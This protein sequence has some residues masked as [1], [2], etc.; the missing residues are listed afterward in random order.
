MPKLLTYIPCEKVVIDS[1]TNN[2]SITS[3]ISEIEIKIPHGVPLPSK[4]TFVPMQWNILSVWEWED[5]DTN[6]MFE[7]KSVLI[8]QSGELLLETTLT[9]FRREQHKR[10]HRNIDQ[11]V[12]FPVWVP[13]RSELRLMFRRGSSG[14]FSQI[15]SFPIMVLHGSVH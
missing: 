2:V 1:L 15:A 8:S 14:E 12:G 13:G 3:L 10:F 11:I 4:G 9:E 6:L 7:T 5:Q